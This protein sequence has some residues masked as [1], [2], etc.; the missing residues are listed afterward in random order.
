VALVLGSTPAHLAI[1]LG[2]SLMGAVAVPL[3]PAHPDDVLLDLARRSDATVVVASPDRGFPG[4]LDAAVLAAPPG[5]APPGIPENRATPEADREP[6]DPWAILYTSGS[7]SRPR[8]VVIPQ[9]A[10][11]VAG[12]ALAGAH[13]YTARDTV[14]CVL[15]L[16]HASA[17]LMSW[18][19]AAAA[20]A[21]L[22]LAE[23]FSVSGFWSLVRQ[24]GATVTIVVPT[25]A[26]LLV[27]A[28]P[29]ADDREHPLRLLITHYDVPAFR[30]RF[31]VEVRTLWGMTETSGLGLTTRAGEPTAG[32]VVGRPYPADA[33]VRLVD[34]AG[35]DVPR[36]EVGEL[37]FA[38]R[39]VMSGYQGEPPP[40]G[41]WI[42]SG[43]LMREL[44]AGFA[45]VGRAKTVIKRGGENI[46]AHEVERVIAGYPGVREAVV[47]PVPDRVFVEEACAIVVW[48]GYAE[49]AGLREFCAGQLAGWKVPRYIA[50][51]PGALPKL[52]NQ[53]I[54]R[55]RVRAGLDL[56]SAHDRGPRT[57]RPKEDDDV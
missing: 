30:E 41:G 10:F 8:G 1:L 20:G 21:S 24:A 27:T 57:P 15:P 47:V 9:R 54:D 4:A 46:S 42:A 52:S 56:S 37:L 19:P 3:D 14:L 38:H 32:G 28:P 12:R 18:A 16:H 48:A 39:A 5:I 13:G 50:G 22:V 53:K 40:P 26:E 31:G 11:D 23:R 17:T 29:A 34:S 7:T 45:Y 51:W 36:G 55:R 44:P 49:V 25:I 6:D 35:Q 2:L 43:D 33:L